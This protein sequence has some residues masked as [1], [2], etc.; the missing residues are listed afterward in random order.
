VSI[1]AI[2]SKRCEKRPSSSNN[3]RPVERQQKRDHSEKGFPVIQL[4]L[5]FGFPAPDAA[6]KKFVPVYRHE[7][8]RKAHGGVLAVKNG[9]SSPLGV[10]LCLSAL[11]GE[12]G[13]FP[14]SPTSRTFS[15]YTD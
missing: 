14:K 6:D 2:S 1:V 13:N 8:L 15:R 11:A 4:L 9:A 7:E 12:R 10:K 5:K 3:H